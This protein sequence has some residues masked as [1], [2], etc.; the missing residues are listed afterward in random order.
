MAAFEDVGIQLVDMP[1]VS[2]DH[3]ESWVFGLLRNADALLV[4]FDLAGDPL[5]D[6]EKT[7]ALLSERGKI[8]PR[9]AGTPE[10]ADRAIE[11]LHEPEKDATGFVVALL[12]PRFGQIQQI[13]GSGVVSLDQEPGRLVQ[14]QQVVVFMKHRPALMQ[15]RNH[16]VTPTS[17][18]AYL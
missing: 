14:D 8:V 17:K 4:V 3:T 2:E 13:G 18:Q 1:P 10:P 7:F 16:V 5:G 9:R 15:K 12:E 11:A 6:I